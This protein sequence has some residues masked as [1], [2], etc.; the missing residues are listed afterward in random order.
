MNTKQKVVIAKELVIN[1]KLIGLGVIIG[2]FTLLIYGIVVYPGHTHYRAPFYEDSRWPSSDC[3]DAVFVKEWEVNIGDY[4]Y[5][6][7]SNES[8]YDTSAYCICISST[9]S[10]KYPPYPQI[11]DVIEA[12]NITRFELYKDDLM[13]F[14]LYSIIISII[15]VILGR[16]LLKFAYFSII[17]IRKYSNINI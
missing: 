7:F 6:Y 2:L 17:W 9:K 15:F 10:Y 3:G 5:H 1:F 4:F 13:T 11:S 12:I 16:Y 14:G 8:K